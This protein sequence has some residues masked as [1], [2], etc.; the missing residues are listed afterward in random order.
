MQ[1]VVG[2]DG[3]EYMSVAARF[4]LMEKWA[5]PQFAFHHPESVF[6]FGQRDVN[7]PDFIVG[8]VWTAAAQVIAA[9][10]FGI[11]LILIVVT[12]PGKLAG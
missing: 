1:E 12:S 4:L 2:K 10:Q 11:G 8:Q 5:Q 3:N 9:V 7:M 6:N